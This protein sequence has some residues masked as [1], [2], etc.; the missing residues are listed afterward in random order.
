MT[1]C[2]V[3]GFFPSNADRYY[4]KLIELPKHLSAYSSPGTNQL[5]RLVVFYNEEDNE[6]LPWHVAYEVPDTMHACWTQL[7]AKDVSSHSARK[8]AWEDARKI[9]KGKA[10]PVL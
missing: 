1:L 4:L 6:K 5:C 9:S 7:I 2:H 3:V 10:V 8:E